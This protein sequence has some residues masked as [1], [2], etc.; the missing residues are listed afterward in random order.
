M[1]SLNNGC[2]CNAYRHNS[3]WVWPRS[4]LGIGWE[5][6]FDLGLGFELGLGQ[7]SN[8]THSKTVR[9]NVT[10]LIR[11]TVTAFVRVG[12]SVRVSG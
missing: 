9:V 7:R 8:R 12:A 11:S 3:D 6:G 2:T 1:L 10:R 5:F 4:E